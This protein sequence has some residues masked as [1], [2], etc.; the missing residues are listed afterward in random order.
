[1]FIFEFNKEQMFFLS[2]KK[3]DLKV[4]SS[5]YGRTNYNEFIMFLSS[6]PDLEQKPENYFTFKYKVFF[7]LKNF[8]GWKDDN[9]NVDLKI[10]IRRITY[11]LSCK[12]PESEVWIDIFHG[13]NKELF[14]EKFFKSGFKKISELF[15]NKSIL[16]KFQYNEKISIMDY[17]K[18]RSYT[19]FR[20]EDNSFGFG[21]PFTIWKYDKSSSEVIS[22]VGKDNRIQTVN[23]FKYFIEIGGYIIKD[24][25]LEGLLPKE[26]TVFDVDYG[27]ISSQSVRI[28]ENV[29]KDNE[30][31]SLFYEKYNGISHYKYLI[32]KGRMIDFSDN[33]YYKEN[34]DH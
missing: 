22:R 27:Y 23:L 13:R 6:I 28:T 33:I 14:L 2:R 3:M 21:S 8:T 29:I 15:F 12:V 34:I 26:Y 19:L 30:Q 20:Y 31:T 5:D 1:M 10:E 9:C 24:D 32:R 7:T 4:S 18:K 25:Y 16:S 11:I 17:E